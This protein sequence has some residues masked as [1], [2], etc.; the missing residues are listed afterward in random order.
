MLLSQLD[1]PKKIVTAFSKKH[2]HTVDDLLRWF[3]RKYRD[4]RETKDIA[5]CA[6]GGYYAVSGK[7]MK[8]QAKQGAKGKYLRLSFL[9]EGKKDAEGNDI[10]FRVDKF[11][12]RYTAFLE[13]VYTREY[14]GKD[15][16]VTG[17]V[18]K[19]P[20]YGT[21][22]ADAEVSLPVLFRNEIAAV[23]PK[24]GSVKDEDFR[25]WLEQ[26]IQLSGEVLEDEIREKAG[27]YSYRDALN[28]V[29]HPQSIDDIYKA[30]EQF[31]FYDLFW[32]YSKL[33]E[34]NAHMPEKSEL[35]FKD[36]SLMERFISL[37]P[38]QLT[39]LEAYEEG[40][41]Q[42]NMTHGGQREAI[43]SMASEMATGK[44]LNA[45]VEG[46][47]GCGKTLVAAA[48]IM[49]AAGNGYQACILAPKTV[50]ARQ[51]YEEIKQ[52]C[53]K[54]GL[55]CAFLSGTA[56][57][58]QEKKEKKETLKKIK[59]GSIQVIV[60]THSCFGKDVEYRALG[61]IVYDEEQIF[62]VDQKLCMFEK[63]LPGVHTVEMSATPIPR[64]L[65]MSVYGS[66]SIYRIT[67][68]PAGRIPIQTAAINND[69]PAFNFIEKQLGMGRQCYVVAPAI[70]DNEDSDLVGVNTVAEKYHERFAP[71]GYKVVVAN[72][73]MK[74][75]EFAKAIDSFKS[76]EAQILVA[77]TVIEVGVNVPNATVIAIEQAE[78]FGLSQLHQL[79]G[80]VGR[81]DFKSYCILLTKDKENQRIMAMERI[82][83]GFEIAEEDYRLR[84]PGDV[85][86]TDQSGQN[87]YIDEILS[88]PHVYE[89]AKVA[90]DA[91]NEKNRYG[92]MLKHIYREHEM[93]EGK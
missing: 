64:S 5:D 63:G 14:L 55:S 80:R 34:M 17:K 76:G 10:W 3:P 71:L 37:L 4:Y 66:K 45:L 77:T 47:V 39:G 11:A 33:K 73:K 41:K 83:D 46:D 42:G 15:V 23:Y 57:T 62:G 16:V 40:W 7:L 92:L 56:K 86:G 32:F 90:A 79:R 89:K 28:M 74:D 21:S 26:F 43:W 19:H 65:S 59:E 85:N 49:L 6:D 22:M 31:V 20:V 91:C 68:K 69:R 48:M 81:K 52:Y 35:L 82:S 93:A 84:G 54:M 88:F 13:T 51:H 27:I 30:R 53:E 75:E 61:L 67:K 70:E 44:R 36:A 58:A 25:S 78:R 29:H 38:F 24:T 1:M 8:V 12:S 60:G 2:I 9:S 87:L 18:I 72:G 50:L